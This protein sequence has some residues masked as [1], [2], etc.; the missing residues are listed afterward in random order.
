MIETHHIPHCFAYRWAGEGESEADYG[1]RAAN[2]L[3]AKILELGEDAVMAF[4]PSRHD[5]YF[6]EQ[7]LHQSQ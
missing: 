5:G 7:L 3:E 1:L 4:V 2:E 6:A